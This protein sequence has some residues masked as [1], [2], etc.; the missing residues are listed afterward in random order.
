MFAKKIEKLLLGKGLDASKKAGEFLG[1]KIEDAVTKSNNVY[2]EK[3][4]P[5]EKIVFMP[6]KREEILNKLRTVLTKSP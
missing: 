1:N 5:I 4:E 2:I 6:D 3:Q